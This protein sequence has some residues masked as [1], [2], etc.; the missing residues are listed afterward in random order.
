MF[1]ERGVVKVFLQLDLV[2]KGEGCTKLYLVFLSV[3]SVAPFSVALYEMDRGK[4]VFS[5]D[6]VYIVNYTVFVQ[7]YC[8]LERTVLLLFAEN[9]LDVGVYDRLLF[10]H[11]VIVFRFNVN[12]CKHLKI[13]LPADACSGSFARGRF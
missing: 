12:I 2:G 4:S 9:K 8:F 3:L 10:Q 13:G 7:I 6:L 1:K 11:I 5:D